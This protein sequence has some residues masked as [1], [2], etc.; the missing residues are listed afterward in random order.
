MLYADFNLSELIGK[1]IRVVVDRP[2]G[3]CHGEII[4]PINYGFV[5]GLM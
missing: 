4:Y 5:P 1:S 3:Y 2:V